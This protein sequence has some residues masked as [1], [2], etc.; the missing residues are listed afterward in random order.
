MGSLL[1]RL[2]ANLNIVTAV[3]LISLII[4]TYNQ[5]IMLALILMSLSLFLCILLLNQIAREQQHLANTLQDNQQALM[6]TAINTLLTNKALSV[7]APTAIAITQLNKHYIRSYSEINN[8]NL[9]I[10]YSAQEL[11]INAE[12][13][14]KQSHVQHQNCITTAAATEQ[15]NVSLIDISQRIEGINN[16]VINSKS[17]CNHSFKVLV[18][19]KEQV[20]LVNDVIIHTQQSLQQLKDKLDTVI[21]MSNIISDMAAQTNLLAINASIEAAKAGE[22][23]RGFSV[24]ATEM[25]ML[26]QRSET[27]SL[28][29]TN[30]TKEVTMN[31]QVVENH[32]Q[33]AIG[34]ISQS[35]V[36]MASACD[37]LNDIVNMT[38]SMAL[39]IN[40]VAVATEQ[41]MY[42]LKDITESVEQITALAAQNSYMSIQQADVANHLR[43][44]TH[45]TE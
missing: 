7:L 27:S 36:Q 13:T 23:G 21:L 20:N 30:K 12:N 10:E 17:N 40:G 4:L 19:S 1:T 3:L 14:A 24:V 34:H 35:G 2:F 16:A 5:L 37:N 29:I 41:Q 32:M 39:D 44:I 15:I 6:S 43:H 9:E 33:D 22:Y 11:A 42:A 8:Q 45:I 25:K 18:G 26:A 38:E 28:T 31:M